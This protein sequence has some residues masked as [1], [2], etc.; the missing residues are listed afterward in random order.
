MY[1]SPSIVPMGSV[2]DQTKLIYLKLGLLE[3]DAMGPGASGGQAIN[4]NVLQDN[5]ASVQLSGAVN[6]SVNIL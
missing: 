5:L 1:T 3:P 6:L 4:V 2:L